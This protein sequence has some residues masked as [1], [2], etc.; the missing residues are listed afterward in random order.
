MPVPESTVLA[1]LNG[2]NLPRNFSYRLAVPTKRFNI[3]DTYNYQIIQYSKYFLTSQS[4]ISWSFD[5]CPLDYKQI[6]TL[7]MLHLP[8]LTFTGYWGDSF[9][10]VFIELDQPEVSARIF[11][12]SG[13]FKITKVITELFS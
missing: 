12:I 8:E 7:Y 13:K 5:G 9:K 2:Q 3:V 10:V 11:K 1:T 4:E 6:Y